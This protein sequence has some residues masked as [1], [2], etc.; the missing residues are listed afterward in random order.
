VIHSWLHRTLPLVG[1]LLVC[2]LLSLSPSVGLTCPMHVVDSA[3]WLDRG[4]EPAADWSTALVVRRTECN[5]ARAGRLA[6][7]AL[8]SVWTAGNLGPP[9]QDSLGPLEPVGP[10]QVAGQAGNS[11]QPPRVKFLA[12]IAGFPPP[13][14]Q[15]EVL[16]QPLASVSFQSANFVC[17]SKKYSLTFF[18]APQFT[19]W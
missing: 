3:S 15:N 19:R 8:D 11:I 6:S 4:R 1:L 2:L 12:E 9:G 10:R 17:R 5:Q 7:V 13:N 16:H 14:L 18:L